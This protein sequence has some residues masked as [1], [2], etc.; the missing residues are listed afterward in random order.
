VGQLDERMIPNDIR[1]PQQDEASLIVEGKRPQ[2]DGFHHAVERGCGADAER[3][4]SHDDGG[5]RRLPHCKP[6]GDGHLRSFLVSVSAA[7]RSS[8]S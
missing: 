2:D 7:V 6:S 3:Q 1:L 8:T 5:E 4:R